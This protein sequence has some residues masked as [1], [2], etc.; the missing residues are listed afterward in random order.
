VRQR[1]RRSR[2]GLLFVQSMESC[3]RGPEHVRSALGNGRS[4][5]GNVVPGASIAAGAERESAPDTVNEMA[6]E[7]APKSASSYLIFTTGVFG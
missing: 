2:V 3:D 1:W 6:W 5:G 7:L 4:F